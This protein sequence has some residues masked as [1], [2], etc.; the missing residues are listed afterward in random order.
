MNGVSSRT[1]LFGLVV[2]LA[3][4]GQTTGPGGLALSKP[5]PAFRGTDAKGRPI[6]LADFRGQVVLLDFWRTG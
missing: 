5:A 1:A 2:L 3:G 4:C 6:A